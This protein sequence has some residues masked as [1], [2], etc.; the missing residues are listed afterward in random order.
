[1]PGELDPTLW[2]KATVQFEG[3]LPERNFGSQVALNCFHVVE[4]EI[5]GG[6]DP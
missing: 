5:V 1:L 2:G 3:E 4:V 6:D